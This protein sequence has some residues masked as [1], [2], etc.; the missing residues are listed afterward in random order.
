MTKRLIAATALSLSVPAGAQLYPT[1]IAPGL[2]DR[3]VH[4]GYAQ[5]GR[6][7]RRGKVE[8]KTAAQVAKERDCD[9][10]W[11]RRGQMAR[12]ERIRLYDECPR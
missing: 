5:R 7:R 8:K 11:K 9:A 4:E 6:D 2:L 12:P 3:A 1:D 10:R